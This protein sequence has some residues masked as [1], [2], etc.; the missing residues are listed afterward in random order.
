MREF[1]ST[2]TV[3]NTKILPVC[4]RKHIFKKKI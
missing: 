1:V 3:L 4:L 2:K